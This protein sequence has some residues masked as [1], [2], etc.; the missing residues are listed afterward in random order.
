M[1]TH[2][3][4]SLTDD[5]DQA[6]IR[7]LAFLQGLNNPISMRCGSVDQAMTAQNSDQYSLEVAEVS[8]ERACAYN[9]EPGPGAP[10]QTAEN[11]DDFVF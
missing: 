7:Q 2:L 9:S 5:T 8:E 3:E 10:H 4:A 6:T 1:K 11:D